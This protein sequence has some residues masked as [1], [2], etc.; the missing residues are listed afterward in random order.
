MGLLSREGAPP[1]G[2]P[3]EK[4][5]PLCRP[6]LLGVCYRGHNKSQDNVVRWVSLPRGRVMLSSAMG[7]RRP[8]GSGELMEGWEQ[9][10]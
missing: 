8:I 2:A 1:H 6:A 9:R 5:H 3:E 10:A 4:A 7:L